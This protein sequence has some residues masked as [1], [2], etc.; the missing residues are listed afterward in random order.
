M[1]LLFPVLLSTALA[2]KIEIVGAG[3]GFTGVVGFAHALSL[4]MMINSESW[5]GGFIKLH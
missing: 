5:R 1:T 3:I 4:E 2:Q